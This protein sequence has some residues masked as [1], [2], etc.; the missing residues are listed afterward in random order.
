MKV[1]WLDWP[2]SAERAW[3]RMGEQGECETS[4]R[5]SQA[6][7]MHAPDGSME[8]DYRVASPMTGN[9]GETKLTKLTLITNGTT[10]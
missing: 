3:Y 5:I 4:K 6:E 1:D 2:L 10:E 9:G 8:K 7:S